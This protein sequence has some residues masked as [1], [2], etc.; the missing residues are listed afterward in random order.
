M[1]KLFTLVSIAAVLGVCTLAQAQSQDT[2]LARIDNNKKDEALPKAP[3]KQT[4]N[5]DERVSV[6]PNAETN[7]KFILPHV[8]EKNSKG[9]LNK[10]GP[11]GEDVFMENRKYYYINSEGQKVKVKSTELREKPKHS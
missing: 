5:T 9:S 1:K 11:Q 8:N 6:P 3:E 10:V 4:G 2:S 7:A